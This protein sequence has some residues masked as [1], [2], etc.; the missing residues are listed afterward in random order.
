V[1]ESPVLVLSRTRVSLVTCL[2]TPEALDALEADPP[3]PGRLEA[4]RPAPDE[5]LL[6][7]GPGTGEDLIALA[8]AR[9][10]SLDPGSLCVDATDGWTVWTLAGERWSETFAMLS[11]IPLEGPGF[12][13]GRVAEVP[14]KVVA[15]S[16][17]VHLLVP[18]CS[19]EHVRQRILTASA[20]FG[21]REAG[22]PSAWESPSTGAAG[23]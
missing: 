13:Q 3:V 8:E 1:P 11:A 23:S 15:R 18:S 16:D 20:G 5:L 10:S 21:V 7:G 2:G 17:R 6:V 19:E 9:L 12:V 4:L 22:V 14:A